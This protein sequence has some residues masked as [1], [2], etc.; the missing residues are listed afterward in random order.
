MFKIHDDD[1]FDKLKEAKGAFV[2][3]FFDLDENGVM[4]FLVSTIQNGTPMIKSFYNNFLVDSF[5]L[6]TF[7]LN[8]SGK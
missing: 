6:K 4:D 7:V 2:A 3:S 8:A 1:E 5:H